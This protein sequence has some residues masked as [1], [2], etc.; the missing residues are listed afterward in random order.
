MMEKNKNEVIEEWIDAADSDYH[1]VKDC[2]CTDYE[3]K[4][5]GKTI[6]FETIGC[7]QHDVRTDD[8]FED[9]IFT[10]EKLFNNIMY[11]WDNYHIKEVSGDALQEVQALLN[12]DHKYEDGSD[13]FDD[14]IINNIT[15]SIL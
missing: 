7:G 13:E 2:S 11:L 4:Y 12:M 1:E 3:I 8:D 15:W 6:N 9:F 14:F 5:H 10:D